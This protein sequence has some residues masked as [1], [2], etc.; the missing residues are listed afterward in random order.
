VAAILCVF[1]LWSVVG[2]EEK[3]WQ[4]KFCAVRFKSA[5][6]PEG[7]FDFVVLEA[8]LAPASRRTLEVACHHRTRSRRVGW[9][10]VIV[11][12]RQSR[13][14]VVKLWPLLGAIGE[15]RFR[16]GP[17]VGPPDGQVV[18]QVQVVIAG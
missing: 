2:I 10:T 12:L 13:A 3:G 4:K 9:V 8:I 15:S 11:P 18:A 5:V 6:F 7:A 17:L 1:A 16:I 14:A